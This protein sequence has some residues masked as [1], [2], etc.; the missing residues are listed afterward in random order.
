[1]AGVAEEVTLDQFGAWASGLNAELARLDFTQP[2]R[3]VKIALVASTKENFS[4]G[5][6]PDGTVWA[7]LQRARTRN[8]RK[9]DRGLPLRDTGLLMASTA[10]QGRGHVE[11]ITRQ[12]LLFG[13]NLEYA[14]FHQFGTRHIPARQFLGFNEKL[15][16]TVD[17]ILG[18]FVEKKLAASRIRKG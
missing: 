12:E 8:R 7:P 13:S 15:L 5:H 6:T 11:E 2:L 1:M 17:A 10:A 3:S 4:G 16:R 18:E 14:G 9:G